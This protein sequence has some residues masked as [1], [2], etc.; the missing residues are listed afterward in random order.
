[1]RGLSTPTD[2]PS[3]SSTFM[4][5]TAS[6]VRRTKIFK[7]VTMK[8]HKTY[9]SDTP[10]CANVYPY[11]SVSLYGI[12]EN[13]LEYSLSYLPRASCSCVDY[14]YQPN[15][16][17]IAKNVTR[18][19]N[20]RKKLAKRRRHPTTEFLFFRLTIWKTINIKICAL[21]SYRVSGIVLLISSF[22]HRTFRRLDGVF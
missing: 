2:P 14:Y 12:P 10:C 1:M 5:L 4:N 22:S 20:R 17:L 9:Q 18:L 11:R 8:D 6:R 13:H 7:K 16:P 3:I 19:L 15:T 21:K